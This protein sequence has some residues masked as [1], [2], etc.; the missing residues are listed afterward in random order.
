MK[1]YCLLR[2][3]VGWLIQKASFSVHFCVQLQSQKQA[4]KKLQFFLRL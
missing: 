2:I 4:S 1:Q 3:E